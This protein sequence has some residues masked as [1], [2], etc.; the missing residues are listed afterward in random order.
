MTTK[1]TMTKFVQVQRGD[2]GSPETFT[3]IAE[4]TNFKGPS[5]KASTL[6]ATSFDSAGEEFIGGLTDGGELTFDVNY[7]ATDPQQQNL[8]SD[9]TNGTKRNF[10]FVLNDMPVGGSNPTSIAITAFVTQAPDISGGVNQVVKGSCTIKITGLP[11]WT[12][13]S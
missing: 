11:V 5:S 2:G 1:A 3:K 4:V 7:V 6:P 9:M 8:R 12:Y 13:A 10:K